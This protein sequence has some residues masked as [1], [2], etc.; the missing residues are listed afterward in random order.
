MPNLVLFCCGKT[1]S[2]SDGG[3]GHSWP[4]LRGQVAQISG[5]GHVAPEFEKSLTLW[6]FSQRSLQAGLCVYEFSE[7]CNVRH[8]KGSWNSVPVIAFI[9]NQGGSTVSSCRTL[10][11]TSS[12]L[13]ME[14]I[15]IILNMTIQRN[16]ISFKYI[17]DTVRWFKLKLKLPFWF[18]TEWW[19]FSN[20]PM[21]VW[22]WIA[23][24]SCRKLNMERLFWYLAC[25]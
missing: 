11:Q 5:D 17:G 20:V 4:Q 19:H 1:P 14:S 18:S 6:L 3:C 13:T 2:Q 8:E 7:S 25:L 23:R 9:G 24:P 12:T 16:A 15:I 10:A 21:R 22:M